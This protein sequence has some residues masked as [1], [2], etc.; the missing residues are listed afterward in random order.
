MN[1]VLKDGW[2]STLTAD[3]QNWHHSDLREVAY[4]LVHSLF[5]Q[6]VLDGNLNQP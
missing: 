2:P 4:K 5:E 3:S 1:L 6:L